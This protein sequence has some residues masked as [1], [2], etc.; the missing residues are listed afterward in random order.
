MLGSVNKVDL[1]YREVKWGEF[2]RIRIT[3]DIMKP[4]LRRKKINLGLHD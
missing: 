1:D 3:L 2:M 4:L